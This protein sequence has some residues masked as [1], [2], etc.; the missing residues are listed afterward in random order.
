VWLL[1]YAKF[2]FVLTKEAS[3]TIAKSV[4]IVGSFY[5][6]L[7]SYAPEALRAQTPPPTT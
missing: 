4:V 2:L 1:S 6:V 7:G 5:L 3:M